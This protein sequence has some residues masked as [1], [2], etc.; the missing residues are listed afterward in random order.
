MKL[1][2]IGMF[3]IQFYQC[4]TQIPSDQETLTSTLFPLQKQHDLE[5]LLF[6]TV[7]LGATDSDNCFIC[8]LHRTLVHFCICICYNVFAYVIVKR[9]C[10]GKSTGL[11]VLLWQDARSA[12][13]PETALWRP[14]FITGLRLPIPRMTTVDGRRPDIHAATSIARV[15]CAIAH[16]T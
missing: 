4:V 5:E 9:L 6:H 1:K 11:S 10:I 12:W 14:K 8:Y 15:E 3:Y 2:I 16:E 13:V 7:F